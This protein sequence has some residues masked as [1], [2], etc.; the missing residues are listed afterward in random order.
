MGSPAQVKRP[1]SEQEL[2]WKQRGTAEYQHLA[3]RCM[4]S[5][6]ECPPLAEAEPGRPRMEDTGVRPKGQA[7][8]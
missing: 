6:V 1:L 2:A 3:Q 4:N 7:T 5:M 8:A